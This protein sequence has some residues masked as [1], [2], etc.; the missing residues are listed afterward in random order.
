MTGLRRLALAA[1]VLLPLLGSAG[2]A[3][4]ATA[5][6]PEEKA[7]ILSH[8]PWPPRWAPDASNRVAGNARVAQFG[9][10]LFFDAR[11]SISGTVACASCHVPELHW[12]DRRPTAKGLT[13]SDRNTPS[14]VDARLQRWFGW[15]GATDS[16][17]AASLRPL[18]DARE[19]GSAERH[20][21]DALRHVPALAC[22]YRQAFGR[23]PD[24]VPDDELFASTGKALAAFQ[25]TLVSGRT[26]FDDFRDAL[27]RGDRVAQARYPAAARRGLR[28]FVGRGQCN[29]CHLGAVFSNGEFDQVGVSVRLPDGRFDWGRY[30]GIKS[31]Q[32]NRFS[33]TGRFSDAPAGPTAQSTRHVTLT[34]ATLGQFR[35]PG[36]RGVALSA[37]YMHDGSMAT[38]EDVVRH[39]STLDAEKLLLAAPHPH[40]EPG[41]EAVAQQS[42]GLLRTLGLDAGEVADLLS[43]LHTLSESRASRFVR[44]GPDPR[45]E[46]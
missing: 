33:L 41:T 1:L 26:P 28:L 31:L 37:P 44:P 19:M 34:A 6:T 46:K 16:L 45:C 38:L 4:A 8:G 18:T 42:A 7:A 17:W 2:M 20:V 21:V 11:L 5:F 24:Q 13:D 12:T 22:G 25:A 15:S 27:A 30:E 40:A 39:Y 23:A 3:R 14:V 36:L 10:R 29:V 35:V 9:A 32:S 43:F